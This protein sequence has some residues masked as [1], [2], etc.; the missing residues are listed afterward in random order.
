MN[1]RR[2][3]AESVSSFSSSQ[4]TRTVLSILQD[5]D[6]LVLTAQVLAPDC[7]LHLVL[8]LGAEVGC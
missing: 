2:W 5:D 3:S 4:R 6:I 7:L 8:S 1:T